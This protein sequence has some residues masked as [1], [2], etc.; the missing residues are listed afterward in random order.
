MSSATERLLDQCRAIVAAGRKANML[1]FVRLQ[2]ALSE[3]ETAK[4][5][6]QETRFRL[7]SIA[8]SLGRTLETGERAAFHEFS[9]AHYS[10]AT[11]ACHAIAFRQ[12]MASLISAK[13]EHDADLA[14]HRATFGDLN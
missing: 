11:T 7:E 13:M 9:D 14:R 10:K 2:R 5:R 6:L 8:D 12:A 1:P 3:A 4:A